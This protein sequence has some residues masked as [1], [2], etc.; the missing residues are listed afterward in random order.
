HRYFL[1]LLSAATI[2]AEETIT[3]GGVTYTAKATENIANAELDLAS[4]GSAAQNI[5]D[6]AL[7]LVRVINRHASSTVYAYYLS[8]PDDL[9]GKML[10]E[11][12]GIGGSA[13][14][15]TS[16]AAAATWSP[17]LPSSGTSESS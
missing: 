2:S 1:T 9:P 11:E 4:V 13:F 17:P 6:T 16:N 3:I 15:L 7:S 5:R 14:S 12:R 10:L 8:G